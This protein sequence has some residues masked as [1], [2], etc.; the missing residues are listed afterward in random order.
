MYVVRPSASL[1]IVVLCSLDHVAQTDAHR[2][3]FITRSVAGGTCHVV[4]T[5][6][7]QP[8]GYGVLD[9]SFYENGFI[10]QLYID[11]AHRRHGAATALLRRLECLCQTPKLF[12]STN[13]SNQPMQSLLA[14]MGYCLSGVIHDLDACDP[15]LVY[16]KYL[17]TESSRQSAESSKR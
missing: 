9:Y 12:T 10:A 1:D 11:C 4:E 6:A 16:V 15:E 3:E 14:K 8:I 5:N 17:K 13:L 7:G 2:R